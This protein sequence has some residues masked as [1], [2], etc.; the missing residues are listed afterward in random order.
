MACNSNSNENGSES[1][2]DKMCF[3]ANLQSRKKGH[4]HEEKVIHLDGNVVSRNAK[5]MRASEQFTASESASRKAKAEEDVLHKSRFL[6]INKRIKLDLNSCSAHEISSIKGV[7]ARIMEDDFLEHYV[8]QDLTHKCGALKKEGQFLGRRKHSSATR[9]THRNDEMLVKTEEAK[10]ASTKTR[11]SSSSESKH[12]MEGERKER[13]LFRNER[14]NRSTKSQDACSDLSSSLTPPVK[15]KRKCEAEKTKEKIAQRKMKKNN[16][17]LKMIVNNF[18]T[19]V[20]YSFQNGLALKEQPNQ[21][22]DK[23]FL[24]FFLR[25]EVRKMYLIKELTKELETITTSCK[26]NENNFKDISETAESLHSLMSQDLMDRDGEVI[27]EE[28]FRHL[29]FIRFAILGCICMAVFALVVGFIGDWFSLVAF[30]FVALV[31]FLVV[32]GL[33]EVNYLLHRD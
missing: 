22:I 2:H 15:S 19:A 7:T 24:T 11:R 6:N 23:S 28:N 17:R 9:Q 25:R 10:I 12:S 16:E 32:K 31:S 33:F 20:S 4:I 5:S 3:A 29:R 8:D 1:L 14:G 18:I 21:E 26:S 27:I 30:I 13:L